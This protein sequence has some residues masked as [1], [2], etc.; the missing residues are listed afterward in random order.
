VR[1]QLYHPPT[2][3]VHA[4]RRDARA[5]ADELIQPLDTFAALKE[6]PLTTD[7]S[8]LGSA[9]EQVVH[10][11]LR[12]EHTHTAIEWAEVAALVEPTNPRRA[13]IAGRVTRNANEYERAEVWFKRGIGYA[14]EQ[15]DV[16]EQIWGHLGYGRVCQEL[17]WV[18][19]ARKH[20]SRGSHLAW[21]KGP[22]SLAASAQHDLA[23]MLMVRGFLTE[24]GQRARR[25]F[26]WYPK[27]HERIPYFAVDVGLMLVL[28]GRFAPA[29][30]LLR[31]SLRSIEQPS[32]RT[33]VLA[34][35]ARAFAGMGEPEAS[36]FMRH[37]ALKML[38]KYRQMEPVTLWH[39]ADAHRLSGNWSA[40]EAE[41]EHALNVAVEQNDHEIARLTRLLIR[42]ITERRPARRKSAGPDDLRE[43]L[44][45]LTSRLAEWSP[46]RGRKYP[47]PWG[48]DRAA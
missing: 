17:G 29:A 13:N 36:A 19:G 23:A 15:N 22:P 4:K 5:C 21:K 48:E 9:C 2:I 32:V 14:R 40:A 3:E 11:A 31:T 7:P 30:R 45:L 37:R 10:W 6:N 24:A 26:L 33:M 47:G 43:F 20:L 12:G 18:N 28:G 35:A 1:A 42:W 38:S 27:N 44:R 39:L 34:L 8:K 41:A 46:R 25:A 16:I